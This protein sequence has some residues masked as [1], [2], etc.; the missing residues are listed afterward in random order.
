M[1]QKTR[2]IFFS[3]GGGSVHDSTAAS[4]LKDHDAP[5]QAGP[6]APKSGQQRKAG[7]VPHGDNNVER[8]SANFGRKEAWQSPEQPTIRTQGRR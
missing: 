7:T 2:H 3:L 4:E 6:A 1:G 5:Q 8:F